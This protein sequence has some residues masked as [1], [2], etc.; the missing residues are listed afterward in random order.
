MIV[1]IRLKAQYMLKKKKKAHTP[2]Q[3]KNKEQTSQGWADDE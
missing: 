1:R 2:Q 3:N